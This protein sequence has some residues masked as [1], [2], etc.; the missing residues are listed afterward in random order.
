MMHYTIR[1]TCEITFL[2]VHSMSDAVTFI[3]LSLVG[4]KSIII[5]TIIIIISSLNFFQ[6]LMC[7]TKYKYNKV[8]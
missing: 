5:I 7:I 3:Q 4:F 6:R 1:V 8:P 2:F